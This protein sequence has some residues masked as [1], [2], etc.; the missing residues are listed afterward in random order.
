M[1]KFKNILSDLYYRITALPL[2]F[3]LWIIILMW[4]YRIG[5]QH[6]RLMKNRG[7]LDQ[8]W[9]LSERLE[10]QKRE[11]QA[12]KLKKFEKEFLFLENDIKEYEEKYLTTKEYLDRSW[13]KVI[14]PH[15]GEQK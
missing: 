10:G 7:K 6:Y 11:K 1:K 15:F 4:K 13:Q 14:D 2:L 5:G 9:L 3:L 12:K 8:I